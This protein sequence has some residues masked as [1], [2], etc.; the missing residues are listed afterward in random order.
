MKRRLNLD[1]AAIIAIAAGGA[2]WFNAL[3][4][5]DGRHPAPLFSTAPPASQSRSSDKAPVRTRVEAAAK[6][7]ELQHGL[8]DLGFYDGPVDGIDGPHTRMAVAA[9]QKANGLD[10]TGTPDKGLYRQVRLA[11]RDVPPVPPLPPTPDPEKRLLAVQKV[12]AELGYSPGRIDGRLGSKTRAA[13]A[14]FE[15]DHGLKVT[16]H[17]SAALMRKLSAVSGVAFD[18]AAGAA[19]AD[20]RLVAA[21]P[22]R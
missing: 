8:R 2:V 10:S 11:S 21:E 5:Q 20:D 9:Y 4:L 7:R 6:M 15:R 12:L 1:L 3:W 18:E 17:M 19:F 22:A 16:G 13:I 14:R